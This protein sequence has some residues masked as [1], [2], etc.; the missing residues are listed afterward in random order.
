MKALEKIN[1]AQLFCQKSGDYFPSVG[2][3]E[4]QLFICFVLCD[5]AIEELS[6][7]CFL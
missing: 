3:S 5:T 1:L 2:Y 7:E 4:K 6:A